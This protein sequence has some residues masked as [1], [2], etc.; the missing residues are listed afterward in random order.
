MFKL[1]VH[2]E[3]V[4]IFLLNIGR[5]PSL[6]LVMLGNVTALLLLIVVCQ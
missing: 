4:M 6:H 3:F 5:S 2:G 1:D